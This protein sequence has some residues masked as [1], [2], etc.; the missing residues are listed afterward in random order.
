MS[1]CRKLQA[2]RY[3]ASGR[4]DRHRLFDRIGTDE[5]RDVVFIEPLNERAQRRRVIYG[6]NSDHR[7][8]QR[9]AAA[10][11]DVLSEVTGLMNRPRDDNPF[12]GKRLVAVSCCH[13]P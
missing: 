1:H 11:A 3:T 9:V 6:R 4:D 7:K 10:G 8:Q 5:D 12:A 13:R 2:A